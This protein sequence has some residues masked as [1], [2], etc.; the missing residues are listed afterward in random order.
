MKAYKGG[1]TAQL[2]IRISPRNKAMIQS[3]KIGKLSESDIIVMACQ[4]IAN[5]NEAERIELLEKLNETH[6]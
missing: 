5:M 1:K 2:K 6:A 4:H 3:L